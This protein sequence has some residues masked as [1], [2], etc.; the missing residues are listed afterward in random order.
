MARFLPY[1]VNDERNY[2]RR[3][4]RRARITNDPF[5]LPNQRFIEL[6]LFDKRTM[7]EVIDMIEPHMMPGQRGHRI[8]RQIRILAAIRF[9]ACGSYQRCVGQDCFINLSQSEISIAVNEVTH[10]TEAHL[11]MHLFGE[12]VTLTHTM[13]QMRLTEDGDRNSSL[14][15]DSGYPLMP[16]LLTP[17]THPPENT[18]ESRFNNAHRRARSCI[19]QCIG[20]LKARFRCLLSER[21]LRYSPPKADTIVNAYVILHNIMV[22]GDLPL[23]PEVDIKKYAGVLKQA[24]FI[25]GAKNLCED[26]RKLYKVN[27]KLRA[28]VSYLTPRKTICKKQSRLDQDE[29]IE[30]VLQPLNNT[31]ANFVKPQ[32]K[33]ARVAPKGRRYT[34]DDKIMDLILHKQSSRAYRLFSKIFPLPSRI[35]I[36]SLLN[37]IPI[38][39]GINEVLF[40]NL[41]AKVKSLKEKEK[42]CV[43]MFDE[44]MIDPHISLNSSIKEFEG[45]EDFGDT[46]DGKIADRALVFLIKGIT[47]GRH[48]SSFWKNSP[49]LVRRGLS[50]W[51][52]WCRALCQNSA[53]QNSAKQNSAVVTALGQK[54]AGHNSAGQNSV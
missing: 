36:M 27:K 47:H 50:T 14:L 41:K 12:R 34:L 3:L 4:K 21:T 13:L 10:H 19:E 8:S 53:G 9:L 49:E 37:R 1:S 17:F 54:S 28:R 51:V 48:T 22:E 18:P 24:G 6:F 45:F 26:A 32:I 44:V 52:D 29:L 42:H 43:V 20:I 5:D 39:A 11:M 33:I 35:T 2:L 40:D 15:G 46:R 7:R 31:L 23:P 16:Y 38:R 30:K 25:S